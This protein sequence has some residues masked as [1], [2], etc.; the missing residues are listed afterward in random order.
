[1][2]QPTPQQAGSI[3]PSLT[4]RIFFPNT[5]RVD[6]DEA[7]SLRKLATLCLRFDRAGSAERRVVGEIERRSVCASCAGRAPMGALSP[8]I[9]T[10]SNKCNAV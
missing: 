7:A 9:R 6:L 4:M 10:R 2:P 3:Y 8:K 5:D 1:M